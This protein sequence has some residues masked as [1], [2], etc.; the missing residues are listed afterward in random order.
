MKKVFIDYDSTLV[1][2]AESWC[3]W[4]FTNYDKRITT[5]DILYWTWIENT[6]GKE[7]DDFFKDY[8]IYA[9]NVVKPTK[10]SQ[11]FVDDVISM[12]G[13]SYVYIITS[14][15]PGTEKA[16][17]DHILRNY[18]IDKYNIINSYQKHE[19]TKDSVLID[20]NINTIKEHCFKNKTIGVVFD[21]GGNYGWSKLTNIMGE[22]K[23]IAN[24]IRVRENYNSI[25]KLLR[26]EY[27]NDWI[28][29]LWECA[30]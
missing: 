7:A 14:S 1:N 26:E 5:K 30:D 3:K 10:N 25:L 23:P 8:R 19:Y 21:K 11:K 20:D 12:Y 6:F 29:R 2:L 17:K 16:K 9:D 28:A 4:I 22:I 18:N 15:Y 24:Y 13:K 27:K